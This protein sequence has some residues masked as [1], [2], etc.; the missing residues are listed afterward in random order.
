MTAMDISLDIEGGYIIG[1]SR[2]RL[3]FTNTFPIVISRKFYPALIQI[4][5][6]DRYEILHMARHMAAVA[7]ANFVAK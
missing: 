7:C 2:S 1:N 5:G 3:H 6:D 4:V